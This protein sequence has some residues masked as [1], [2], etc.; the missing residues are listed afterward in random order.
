MF[1]AEIYTERRKKLKQ[2][3]GEGLILFLGNKE[4]AMNY[5]SN[6][7]PFR[8]D[9]SFLYYFGLDIP[10]IVGLIDIEGEDEVI[11][12]NEAGIEEVI[13]TGQ[14][15]K[16]SELALKVGINRVK[17]IERL[18]TDIFKAI[19]R[20]RKIHYLPPYRDQRR[21]Q[22]AYYENTEFEEVDRNA[23][24]ALIQAV[25]EQRSIK[26]E[27]EIAEMEN[28]MNNVT[29]PAYKLARSSI[30]PDIYEYEIAG[31]LEGFALKKNCQMAYPVICSTR[32]EIL[33]NHYYGNLIKKEH[34]LL[35]DAGAE[36][37]MHYATD[38]TR[39]YPAGGKFTS[40]QKD[41]YNIV[42]QSQ[43]AAI[44]AIKAGVPYIDVHTVAAGIIASGLRDMGLMKGDVEDAVKHG[45]HALFFPHGIG[46]MIGLDV[47]D[48][49]D[50]GEDFVGYDNEFK[51]SLQFGTS[52]LRMAKRL[53][54]G[55]VVTVEPGIYF[56]DSLIDKWYGEGRFRDYIHY[57]TV[58]KFRGFGGIRIEDNVLVT[59]DGHKLIGAPIPKEISD[60]ED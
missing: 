44:S 54:E 49:E 36:S 39:T 57:R 30:R 26:S 45:A 14:K 17:T 24:I 43:L 50:L 31:I 37:T 33:H 59:E 4:I 13:W 41:L 48:M 7:Y 15:E 18:D 1:P 22:L 60:I 51:R 20:N 3:V 19:A 9:S 58:E 16:I 10:D 53:R 5:P 21:L 56:I 55:N 42:L 27:L 25:V 23:S 29:A 6:S 34:M 38:I 47:H 52:G 35:I 8:Q 2:I 28:T 11:Y 40:R 12:G 46:H 32:G